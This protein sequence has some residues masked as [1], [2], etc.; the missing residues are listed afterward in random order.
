MASDPAHVTNLSW[1]KA[2][3]TEAKNKESRQSILTKGENKM[4]AAAAVVVG[5][6]FNLKI[7]THSSFLQMKARK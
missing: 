3:F 7:G 4:A 1:I 6:R 2:E 5:E